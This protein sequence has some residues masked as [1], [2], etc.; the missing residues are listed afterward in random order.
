M[1]GSDE[2]APYSPNTLRTVDLTPKPVGLYSVAKVF[3]EALGYHYATTHG[4]SV[5]CV[6]IG[7][8]SAERPEPSHP[9]QL[10][11]GDCVFLFRHAATHPLAA[12][13]AHRAAKDRGGVR[14]EVFYGVSASEWPLY[15]MQHGREAIGYWPMQ[16]SEPPA[17]GD[18]RAWPSRWRSG[19]AASKL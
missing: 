14:F 13:G 17:E 11:H 1:G 15:D 8:F 5:V 7:N 6:R 3:G 19:G 16:R 18:D 4:M 2:G 12:P 9:H 10:G